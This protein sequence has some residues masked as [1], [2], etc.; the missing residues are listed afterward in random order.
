MIE[1]DF[2]DWLKNELEHRDISQYSLSKRTGISP[3]TIS[4]Y[5]K[6][7]RSPSLYSFLVVLEALGKKIEIV[8][9]P[10]K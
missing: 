1:F 9:K 5:V 8:R 10:L 3:Q 2:T 7:T 6:G 4:G